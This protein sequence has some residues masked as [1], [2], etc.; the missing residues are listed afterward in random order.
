MRSSVPGMYFFSSSW[1][2]FSRAMTWWLSV[3]C[4]AFTFSSVHWAC[5]W[6]F[7]RSSIAFH[8]AYIAA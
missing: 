3:G 2:Y 4:P 7:T 8:I 5:S 1:K 6:F